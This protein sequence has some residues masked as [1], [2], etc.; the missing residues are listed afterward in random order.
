VASA[1]AAVQEAAAARALVE[2]FEAGV[3]RALRAGA[4][5]GE[6]DGTSEEGA[7]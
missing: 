4:P 7:G 1:D 3:E 6:T 2:E 5:T